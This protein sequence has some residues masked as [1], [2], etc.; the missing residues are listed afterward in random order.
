MVEL[1]C[2]ILFE[3]NTFIM[4]FFSNIKYHFSLDNQFS[5][6]Y[7][8]LFILKDNLISVLSITIHIMPHSS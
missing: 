8:I 5:K 3:L 7:L 6:A 4:Y 2:D 1:L